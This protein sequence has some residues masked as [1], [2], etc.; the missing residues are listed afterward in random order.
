MTETE[1]QQ[2]VV[3]NIDDIIDKY[4]VHGG[5]KLSI[6]NIT[7]F[8]GIQPD[9][10]V[11]DENTNELIALFECKTGNY[12][13]S[14]GKTKKLGTQHLMTGMGQVMQYYFHIKN[15]LF[16]PTGTI[17]VAD[18]AKTFFA[19]DANVIDNFDWEKLYYPD[20][21]N[22]ILIDSKKLDTECYDF[23]NRKVVSKFNV[24][25]KNE[26]VLNEYFNKEST[27]GEC[28]V[29][30]IEFYYQSTTMPNGKIN[31]NVLDTIFSNPSFHHTHKN[32][33]NFP[34]ALKGLGY[35]DDNNRP[36]RE[37]IRVLKGNYQMFLE[38]LVYQKYNEQIVNIMT[39]LVEMASEN[40]ETVSSITIK[41]YSDIKDKIE[42]M[43]GYPVKFLTNDTSTRYISSWFKILGYDIEAVTK[44]AKNT[45]KINYF[46]F[47][48]L[49]VLGRLK[50]SSAARIQLNNYLDYSFPGKKIE[51]NIID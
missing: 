11:F 18:H 48:E 7:L 20:G 4:T 28:F 36:T 9:V 16:N 25:R 40:N 1:V 13:D 35:I 50:C 8:N 42:G 46:P 44:I 29:S 12:L 15:N 30:L 26:V 3:D 38:E 49:R 17:K 24:R 43:Y 32:T 31:R 2:Y 33:K 47:E 22:V 41:N 6:R 27:F 5:K 39:A 23:S 51:D 45:Y 19:T 14:A 21:F 10:A 37:G 34:I